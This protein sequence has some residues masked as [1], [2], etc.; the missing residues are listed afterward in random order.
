MFIAL[1]LVAAWALLKLWPIVVILATSFILMTALLPFVEWQVAHRVPRTAAV[2][3]IMIAIFATL[4]GVLVLVV[5]ATVDELSDL[6][7]NLPEDARQMDDLLADFGIEADLE[8]RARDIDWDRVV[9]GGTAFDY[10]QRALAIALALLTTLFLT[11]Y[12]LADGPRMNRFLYQFV[13]PGREPEVEHWL[14][15]LRRVVGGY[16]RGQVITTVIISVYTF[17][18]LVAA[19]VPNA[20]AF[21]ILAGFF[22]IIPVIGATLAVLMPTIAA[23][24]ESPTTA[25][26]VLVLL[27]LYQQ[28]ED[29]L[30]APRVYGSTMNLPPVAVLVAVLVGGQLFG[31]AG[32]LLAMPAAATARVGLDYYLEKRTAGQ[33]GPTIGGEEVLAPDTRELERSHA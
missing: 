28:F 8:S 4:A 6:K 14:G 1:A 2:T 10:G 13:P 31:V 26:V 23:F 22:D 16:V 20:A 12:L 5:P 11:A 25:L 21:A 15:T 27:M 19:G 18:V 17:V 33:T 3:V 24:Q 9:S 32:V 29:R 30:L 7:R